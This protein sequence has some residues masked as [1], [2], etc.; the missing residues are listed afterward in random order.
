MRS[1]DEI[2]AEFERLDRLVEDPQFQQTWPEYA[3]TQ[4]YAEWNKLKWI[5]EVHE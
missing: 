3:Q 2:R 1:E 4:I 5:L